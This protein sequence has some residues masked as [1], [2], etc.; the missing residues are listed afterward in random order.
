MIFYHAEHS[1]NFVLHRII[2]LSMFP[3]LIISFWHSTLCFSFLLISQGFLPVQM[4][5]ADRDQENNLNSKIMVTMLSQNPLEPTIGVK[6]MHSRLAQLTLTG[7]FDYDVRVCQFSCAFLGVLNTV[8][9]NWISKIFPLTCFR[10]ERSMRSFLKP[11]ITAI[12]PFP[13]LL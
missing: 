5:V 4:P 13:P 9:R 10:K 6:Q 8:Q 7:C 12:H 3:T 11:E 2:S 1:Q